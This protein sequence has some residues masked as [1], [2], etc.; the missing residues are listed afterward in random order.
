[1]LSK[2]EEKTNKNKNEKDRT[3]CQAKET[4]QRCQKQNIEYWIKN[5]I[6]A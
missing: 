1:M 5:K 2:A 3:I 4:V 6:K